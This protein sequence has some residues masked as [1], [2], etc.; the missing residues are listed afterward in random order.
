MEPP[1]L[2]AAEIKKG[3]Y[4]RPMRRVTQPGAL[5]AKAL[6]KQEKARLRAFMAL[7]LARRA[8][9]VRGRALAPP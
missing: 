2:G 6:R 8:T 9:Q 1:E 4:P 5:V 7:A 3:F